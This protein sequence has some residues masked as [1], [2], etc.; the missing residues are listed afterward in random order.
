MLSTQYTRAGY[1]CVK[2]AVVML[3]R[4]K[5]IIVEGQLAIDILAPTIN[6]TEFIFQK[7]SQTL[8]VKV[9]QVLEAGIRYN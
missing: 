1:A 4:A 5:G 6:V 2:Q 9:S 3:V 8:S 7:K